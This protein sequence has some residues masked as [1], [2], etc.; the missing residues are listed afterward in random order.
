MQKRRARMMACLAEFGVMGAIANCPPFIS[1][2]GARHRLCVGCVTATGHDH[3]QESPPAFSC[4]ANAGR[5]VDT[6]AGLTLLTRAYS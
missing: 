3:L 4:P 6:R 1:N 5:V 2:A